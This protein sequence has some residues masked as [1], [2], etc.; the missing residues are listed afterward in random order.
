MN[1]MHPE[2]IR[3]EIKMKGLSLAD[4]AAMA[5]IG[6]STV[7]QALRKPSTAGEMAIGKV[8]GK[9]LYEL[10][11]ERWTKEGRRIRPRYA[12]LYKEAAA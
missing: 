8:L 3:A 9:P 4:V 2:M 1:G 5:G 11:P 12:Y 7:R 10:W 6:E